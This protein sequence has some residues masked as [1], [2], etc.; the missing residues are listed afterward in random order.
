MLGESGD[1]PEEMGVGVKQVIRDY[2]KP[3]G[4]WMC[5]TIESSGQSESGSPFIAVWGDA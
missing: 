1:C 2:C 5:A 3:G 4:G